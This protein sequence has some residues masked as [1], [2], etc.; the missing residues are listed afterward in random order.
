MVATK[1]NGWRLAPSLVRL[2]EEVD[3]HWPNRPKGSDGSIGD[4]SHAARA[5]EHNPDRDS[6]PMPAGMVSAVDITKMSASGMDELREALIADDRTWYVIHDGTIWSRTHGFSPRKYTGSNSHTHHMHVSLMQTAEAAKSVRSWGL[7]K[8]APAKPADDK[9]AAKPA[10]VPPTLRR[11][12]SDPLLATLQRFL[13]GETLEN[14]FGDRTEAAV[15]S[16][17]AEQK[18]KID[19]I[20]GP[21]TWARILTELKLP[22]YNAK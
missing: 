22:G 2:V 11:G 9:P 18:L 10:K 17:Q 8:A 1:G 12:T 7:G 14:V 16:Y 5:S 20:V 21:K 15:R 3:A 4:A 6:D 19:G 13:L